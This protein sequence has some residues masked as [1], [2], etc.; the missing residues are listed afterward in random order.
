MDI[1]GVHYEVSD[2][3]RDFITEK[4]K[5]ISPFKDLVVRQDVTITKEKSGFTVE[6]NIHLKTGTDIHVHE[7]DLEL[8]PAIERLV[9]KLELKVSKEKDKIK[10]HHH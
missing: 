1:K 8:Y 7:D 5:H 4:M 2:R 10:D 9:D 6:S 3:T